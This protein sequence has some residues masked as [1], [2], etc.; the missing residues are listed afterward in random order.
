VKFPS[1]GVL[2]SRRAPELSVVVA[3]YHMARELPRTLYSLST[4]MQQGI[5]AS[6]YEIIVVDNGSPQPLQPAA[7]AL[8]GMRLS[9]HRFAPAPPSPVRAINFGLRRARGRLIGAMI[10]GARLASPGLLAGAL[11]AA[12]LHARPVISTL[13]FHLGPAEQMKSVAAGYDQHE[14]DRLLVQAGW[15]EDGYRLFDIS[16]LAGSSAGGL[17][18]PIAESNALFMPRALW[19]ELGWFDERFA[20]PGGG[21]ANLDIYV[22]AC[23]LP[24]S[25]L[26]TLLGEGTFHQVHGGIATNAPVSPWDGFHE[27]YR[28]LRGKD[29]ALVER[30]PIYVGRAPPQALRVIEESARLARE[31][32]MPPAAAPE[33]PP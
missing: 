29:F 25:T 8:P 3:A 19:R 4:A 32:R 28:R 12:R 31:R 1:L 2:P 20:A 11:L 18:L 13:G 14:E 27:E 17:F 7:A 23:G 10:D 21:F 24:A 30:E 33:Q 9:W 22:R 6:Q 16:A 26:I 15:T 5:A